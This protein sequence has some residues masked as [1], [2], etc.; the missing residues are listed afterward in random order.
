MII[1][2]YILLIL[3]GVILGILGY[4]TKTPIF[5]VLAFITLAITAVSSAAVEKTYCLPLQN[6][7][8]NTTNIVECGTQKLNDFGL[9][10]YL[11]MLSIIFFIIGMWDTLK[12][13]I[14]RRNL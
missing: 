11:M 5:S 12:T 2:L 8:T 3:A 13:L 14:L 6:S 10:L 4:Y 1:E 7:T 9:V